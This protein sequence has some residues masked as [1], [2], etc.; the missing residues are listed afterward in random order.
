MSKYKFCW[1]WMF[2][3]AL[4]SADILLYFID[5]CILKLSFSTWNYLRKSKK[6]KQTSFEK[7]SMYFVYRKLHFFSFFYFIFDSVEF[8]SCIFFRLKHCPRYWDKIFLFQI[9][10]ILCR[11]NWN[12]AIVMVCHLPIVFAMHILRFVS[13]NLKQPILLLL[14]LLLLNRKLCAVSIRSSNSK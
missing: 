7:C 9:I 8:I 5:Y 12:R 2:M 3:F 1:I 4:K 6:S 14:L 13:V 11:Y 10:F